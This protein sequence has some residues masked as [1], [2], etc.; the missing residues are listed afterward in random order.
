MSR[1]VAALSS[2]ARQYAP[3]ISPR[4]IGVEAEAGDRVSLYLESI[5]RVSAWPWTDISLGR[6]LL[7]RLGKMHTMAAGN[8]IALPEW[9]YEADFHRTAEATI[10]ALDRCRVSSDLPSLAK[11]FAAAR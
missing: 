10:K 2:L 11:D 6:E 4:V 7:V 5:R 9:N 1:E 8:R 3:D